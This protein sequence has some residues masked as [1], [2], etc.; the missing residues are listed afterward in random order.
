MK[1]LQ[2]FED[3]KLSF[4]R[5]YNA[6]Q[7]LE[8][9]HWSAGPG[10]HECSLMYPVVGS[11]S[12]TRFLF[13]W[14]DTTFRECCFSS[15]EEKSLCNIVDPDDNTTTVVREFP[16]YTALGIKTVNGANQKKGPIMLWRP[17]DECRTPAPTPTPTPAPAPTPSPGTCKVDE[18]DCMYATMDLVPWDAAFGGW[19][20]T[21][22]QG[23]STGAL[24]TLPAGW[25]IAQDDAQARKVIRTSWYGT[26]CMV[27]WSGQGYYTQV[28]ETQQFQYGPGD[29]CGIGHLLSSAESTMGDPRCGSYDPSIRCTPY[30]GWDCSQACQYALKFCQ[31]TRILIARARYKNS[32][33]P[34]PYTSSDAGSY[35][36]Y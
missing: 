14:F 27:T 22:Q 4:V 20:D 33:C 11:S 23:G 6:N 5:F 9:S 19:P 35:D 26:S 7:G 28:A 32:A 2:M 36:C 30:A 15:S 12:T 18:R 21:C 16:E 24:M 8:R 10:L 3:H 34:Y 31:V 17:R 1:D 13:A 29:D 25:Y